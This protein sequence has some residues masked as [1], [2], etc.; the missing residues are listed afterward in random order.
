[1]S[2]AKKAKILTTTSGNPVPDNQNSLSAGLCCSR[3]S[4]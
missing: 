4:T 1:M 2:Q 3:I